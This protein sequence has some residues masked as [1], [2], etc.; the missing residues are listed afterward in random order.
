MGTIETHP[1]HAISWVD[2]AAKGQGAAEK[3]YSGLF[4]WSTYNEGEVPYTVFLVG[5]SAVADTP[6]GRA[7]GLVDPWGAVLGVIDRSTATEEASG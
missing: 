4:G 5:E 2:L 1:T 6:F 3:F 7:A